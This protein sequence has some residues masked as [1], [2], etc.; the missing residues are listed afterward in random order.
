[1]GL[2]G[3]LITA[4]ICSFVPGL[5]WGLCFLLVAISDN[6]NGEY[7]NESGWLTVD[8][9]I[10]F[11]LYFLSLSIPIF[12]GYFIILCIFSVVSFVGAER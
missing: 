11:I 10:I 7:I 3:H 8:S 4:T 2:K 1:M 9:F 6:R 5:F 12:I